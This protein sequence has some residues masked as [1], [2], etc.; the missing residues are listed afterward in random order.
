MTSGMVE[1]INLAGTGC[2]MRI[3]A[4]PHPVAGVTDDPWFDTA[5]AVDAYPFS[6]TIET[7]FTLSDFQD[8]A[9]ALRTSED[10]PQQIVLG[11]NRAAE[12][13]MDVERQVGGASDAIVVEVSVTPSGDDPWPLIR[14]LVFDVAP[15]WN[16]TAARVDALG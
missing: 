2:S 4:S 14:F 15:F 9:V 11:G 10:L 5:I 16:D 6:G 8:W 12:V 1:L 13:V 7:I 3:T